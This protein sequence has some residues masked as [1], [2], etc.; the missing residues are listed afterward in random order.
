[1][2]HIQRIPLAERV[3][4]SAAVEADDAIEEDVMAALCTIVVEAGPDAG[5]VAISG[6]GNYFFLTQVLAK[7]TTPIATRTDAKRISVIIPTSK[8]SFCA[9]KPKR[10]A[11]KEFHCR[12]FTYLLAAW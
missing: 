12:T 11:S 7:I 2:Y 4:V 8:T 9:K 3:D 6:A 10:K 1:M 5:V